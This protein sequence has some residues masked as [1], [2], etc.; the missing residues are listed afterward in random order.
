M[1]ITEQGWGRAPR[2]PAPVRV[3]P[4]QTQPGHKSDPAKKS[5]AESTMPATEE[6]TMKDRLL[7]SSNKRESDT[8]KKL[9]R[10]ADGKGWYNFAQASIY[11][12]L[13]GRAPQRRNA[14]VMLVEES[15]R[16][17]RDVERF[18]PNRLTEFETLLEKALQNPQAPRPANSKSKERG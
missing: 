18:T 12:M 1:A 16:W 15:I 9:D 7:P 6:T 10:M 3:R 5:P 17:R 8:A 11:I 2:P 13:N 14:E 4:H